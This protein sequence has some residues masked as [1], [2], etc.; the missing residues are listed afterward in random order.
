LQVHVPGLPWLAV[1]WRNDNRPGI[2][3]GYFLVQ[4]SWG[5]G[6]HDG[7]LFWAPYAWLGMDSPLEK[8]E[9]LIINP[10]TLMNSQDK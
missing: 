8:G 9:K 5:E 7:G 10:W 4:N 2:G 3:G 6:S 1:G